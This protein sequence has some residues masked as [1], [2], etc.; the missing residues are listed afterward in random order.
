MS[1]E[2][3]A[4]VKILP[5]AP[6][7]ESILSEQIGILAALGVRQEFIKGVRSANEENSGLSAADITRLD[8]EW[9]ASKNAGALVQKL[10]SNDIAKQLLSFQSEHQNFREVFVTDSRG[11]NI[12]LTNKTSDYYQ[13]D[14]SWWAAAYSDGAGKPFHG[15]I[16]FD[17]SSQAEAISI[18]VP[19]ISGGT[20]IGVIKGVTDLSDIKSKL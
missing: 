1:S 9:L 15:N 17:Q 7:I 12:G 19:V 3:S 20:V 6:E 14:E 16:E 8:E 18:Y 10:M 13:A 2:Q 11:L 5:L 4:K